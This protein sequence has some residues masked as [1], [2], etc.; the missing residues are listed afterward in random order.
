MNIR[1]TQSIEAFG[2]TIESVLRK[3][4]KGIV[5]EQFILNRIAQAA[6]DTYTM[7]VILSRASLSSKKNV[8]SAQH[9]ILMAQTW[10]LEVFVCLNLFKINTK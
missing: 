9:E 7:A 8:P 1:F 6:F 4:G 2:Q 3:Y 10:C 5:E